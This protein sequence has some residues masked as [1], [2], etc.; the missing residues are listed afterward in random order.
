V[1]HLFLCKVLTTYGNS[2]VRVLML[3]SRGRNA[4]N[5][6]NSLAIPNKHQ[7]KFMC[8]NN[9]FSGSRPKSKAIQILCM[10]CVGKRPG[11]LLALT[12]MLHNRL[13]LSD[14]GMQQTSLINDGKHMEDSDMW[15]APS[16]G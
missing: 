9:V 12:K 15:T 2:Y 8:A 16:P 13:R 6:N 7:I 1:F 14:D 3:Q 4:N 10:V 5:G 11:A